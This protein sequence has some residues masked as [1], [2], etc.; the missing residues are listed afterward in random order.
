MHAVRKVLDR[1]LATSCVALFAILVFTVVWQVVARQVLND[2]SAWSEELAKVVFVWLG[3]FGAALV[4]SER[5]HIAVDFAVRL[6]PESGQRMIAVVVQLAIIGFAAVA[7]V[8]GGWRA[9]ELAW[10]QNLT[11]LPTQIGKIYLVMPITGVIITFYA[12]YHV[13]SV[14]R[15]E[16]PAVEHDD[17]AEAI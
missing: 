5:G 13:I 16:E 9:S 12:I 14:L 1:V 6:L 15:R 11:G 17:I 10:E 8:W 2:A 3:M 4:F 7:L